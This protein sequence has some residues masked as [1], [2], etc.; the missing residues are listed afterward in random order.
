VTDAERKE[1]G[2]SVRIPLVFDDKSNS[3]VSEPRAQPPFVK[4]P[5]FS[6]SIERLLDDGQNAFA[7]IYVYFAAALKSDHQAADLQNDVARQVATALPGASWSEVQLKSPDGRLIS[8]KRLRAEGQQN[9]DNA[10]Q[11]GEV[12]RLDGR[13]DLY[14]VEGPNHYA[15]I[16]FRAPKA[17]ANQY[18]LDTAIE[19][20]MG[21]VQTAGAG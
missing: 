2:V 15:F 10:A 7:P 1:T 20:A 13:F 19:A 4:L 14:L 5:G 6:Y 18:R 12:V 9:F 21:T 11:G 8:V 3:L 16:G 17:Q